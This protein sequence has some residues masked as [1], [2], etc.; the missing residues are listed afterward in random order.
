ME[1]LENMALQHRQFQRLGHCL[2]DFPLL[3]GRFY[4]IHFSVCSKREAGLVYLV[5]WHRYLLDLFETVCV[6]CGSPHS[7]PFLESTSLTIR[8]IPDSDVSL[9]QADLEV[10]YRSQIN[11]CTLYLPFWDPFCV[12]VDSSTV[13]SVDPKLGIV[14]T[15][16]LG[17]T[18]QVATFM[19]FFSPPY[20]QPSFYTEERRPRRGILPLI[21]DSLE[22]NENLL[23][24]SY[25]MGLSQG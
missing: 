17:G 11:L 6:L 1:K 12:V 16:C 15:A 13:L 10:F 25:G 21:F 7:L 4:P 9:P 22:E 20:L 14:L 24:P 2:F 18:L 23:M 8:L 5:W 3:G 19:I